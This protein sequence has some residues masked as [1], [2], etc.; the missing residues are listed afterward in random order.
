MAWRPS[1]YTVA[2]KSPSSRNWSFPY[3]CFHSALLH[4]IPIYCHYFLQAQYTTVLVCNR[5]LES[6]GST[7]K[8]VTKKKIPPPNLEHNTKKPKQYQVFK[9]CAILRPKQTPVRNGINTNPTSGRRGEGGRVS[10]KDQN[11]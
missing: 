11:L 5:Q 6:G 8:R 9:H 4:W 7:S 1:T 3:F 10:C 2:S